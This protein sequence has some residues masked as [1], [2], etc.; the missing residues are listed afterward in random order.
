DDK[1]IVTTKYDG[2]SMRLFKIRI[3]GCGEE[4]LTFHEGNQ[5]YP[6]YSQ[7][8]EWILYTNFSNAYTN[9]FYS[10]YV[11]NTLTHETK[12]VFPES[13]FR[14]SCAS[15]SPDGSKLCY[16]LDFQ[17]AY[18]VYI[19]DFPF[20][21]QAVPALTQAIEVIQMLVTSREI[22]EGTANS[23]TSRLDNA[24]ALLEKDIS[25]AARNELNA[26]INQL[27]AMRGK[28]IPEAE[29]AEM[30]S[31]LEQVINVISNEQKAAK[32]V[33]SVKDQSAEN[34][35]PVSFSLDQNYPN[36]FNPMTTIRFAI[37]GEQSV[38]V[39]LYVYDL[40]GGL[41]RKLVD[42]SRTPGMYTVEWNAADDSGRQ[43]SSGMYLYK[44][45]AGSFVNTKK[46]LLMR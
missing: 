29:A 21:S 28:K 46:M 38:P 17:G 42:D 16:L 35:I 20:E 41:V 7:D 44:L 34:A 4:Q 40:R 18:E 25:N 24:I 27:E 22:S 14:N 2:Q 43:V 8:G 1:Y 39:R 30:I 37:P 19:A 3:D 31:T 33:K 12:P 5:W 45:Q 11:L 32:P 10:I 23:L 15:F 13:P 9:G 6:K 26:C 36:P